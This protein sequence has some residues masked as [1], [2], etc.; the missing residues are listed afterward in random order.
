MS[1]LGRKGFG[2]QAQENITPDSQ[3]S[4][5]EQAK[6]GVTSLGDRAAGA[7]QPEG[8]KSTTQKLGDATRF[9]GD[10][11]SNQGQSVLASTQETVGNAAQS[12]TDTFQGKK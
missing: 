12:I 6:E 1:D 7:I 10:D 11:A 2:E 4:T 9:G 5:L 3:K 8:N